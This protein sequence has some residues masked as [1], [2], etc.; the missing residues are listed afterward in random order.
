M[1]LFWDC[2]S[3]LLGPAV[4]Q[5]ER[6]KRAEARWHSKNLYLEAKVVREANITIRDLFLSRGHLIPPQLMAHAANIV[7]HYDR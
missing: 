6:N 2:L 4:M 5:L 7:E 1:L 3:Q